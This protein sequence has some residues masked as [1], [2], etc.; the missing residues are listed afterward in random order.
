MPFPCHIVIH[1]P[2]DSQRGLLSGLIVWRVGLCGRRVVLFQGRD[3]WRGGLAGL[4]LFI[5]LSRSTASASKLGA[6]TV[7]VMQD[8]FIFSD[9]IANNIAESEGGFGQVGQDL[10]NFQNLSNLNGHQPNGTSNGAVTSSPLGGDRGDKLHKA[11]RTA[12]I[13]EFVEGLPLGFNTMIGARGNGISQGQ[14][15]RMLIARA[16]Y[17]D[18]EFIFLDEATNALDAHNERIIIENLNSF[19]EGRT[20]VVIAHRLSTVRHADQIVVLE[21]GRI[22]EVGTHEELTAQRGGYY[23]L[24]KNQLEL[25]A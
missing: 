12:N 20:V 4:R 7:V 2:R 10:T 3:D 18:P 19:F 14:R 21:K 9:T 23:H 24:V 1:A 15:Q 25:G 16:V 11:A 17:K 5:P 6:A 13:H 22:V 8:G